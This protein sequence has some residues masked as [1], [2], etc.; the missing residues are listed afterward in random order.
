MDVSQTPG[1]SGST[2]VLLDQGA[3]VLHSLERVPFFAGLTAAPVKRRPGSSG[4]VTKTRARH[5]GLWSL[6][7]DRH[8]PM[9]PARVLGRSWV[10]G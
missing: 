5:A 4:S 3:P 10:G 7:L 6:T 2:V 8:Q 1:L 9:T